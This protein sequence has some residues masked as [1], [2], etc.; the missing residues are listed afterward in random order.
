[1]NRKKIRSQ[2][3]FKVEE[4][5]AEERLSIIIT[6][7]IQYINVHSTYWQ[8]YV[9]TAADLVSDS[10][11][12]LNTAGTTVFRQLLVSVPRESTGVYIYCQVMRTSLSSSGIN[13]QI[14]LGFSKSFSSS[15]FCPISVSCQF[16]P[17]FSSFVTPFLVSHTVFLSASPTVPSLFFNLFS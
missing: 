3:F 2:Y 17:W 5:P 4:M 15:S 11:P 8:L 10:G 1:M 16:F 12:Q 9:Y 13:R 6:V 7:I 14:W